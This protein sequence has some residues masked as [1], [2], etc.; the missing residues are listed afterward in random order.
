MEI[1]CIER[2]AWDTLLSHLGVLTFEV[3]A[4]RTQFCPVTPGG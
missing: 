2:R 3:E 1:I 4:M